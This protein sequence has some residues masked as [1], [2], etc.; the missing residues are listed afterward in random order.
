MNFIYSQ[1]LFFIPLI[2]APLILYLI[3]RKKPK[4]MVFS[5]LF[6]LKELAQ[7]INQRT[8]LKDILLLIIRTLIVFSIVMF[9]ASPYLGNYSDY[10]PNLDTSIYIYVDTSTSM[11]LSD[12]NFSVF[13]QTLSSI[14]KFL[15]DIPDRSEIVI[16][17]SDPSKKFIGGKKDAKLFLNEITLSGMQEDIENIVADADSFFMSDKNELNKEFLLFSDGELKTDNWEY[18]KDGYNYSKQLI[19]NSIDTK[20]RTDISIDSVKFDQKNQI[21]C[22]LSSKKIEK[23]SRTKL[24]LYEN[25]NKIY[26]DNIQFENTYKKTEIITYSNISISDKQM[27]FKVD[28]DINI[29]NNIF[30]FIIQGTKR[31]KTLIVGN[32]DDTV[33]KNLQLLINDTSD[34]LFE[35]SQI[36]FNNINTVNMSVY[37]VILFTDLK[38]ISSY[39]VSQLMNFFRSGR[40]VLIALGKDLNLNDYNSNLIPSL[41]FPRISGVKEFKDSYTGIKILTISHP[42]FDKVFVNDVDPKSLEINRYYELEPDGWDIL[43]KVNNSPY[44]LEK[45]IS[46]GK[47][48][49][50][51]SGFDSGS[52]NLIENGFLIPLIYNSIKYF[53]QSSINSELYYNC[54][55]RITVD[56]GNILF[57]PR[58]VE[59]S[60]QSSQEQ[61]IFL[62]YDGFYKLTNEIDSSVKY[63]A[64]NNIREDIDVVSRDML[65]DFDIIDND[66]FV[67]N[68]IFSVERNNYSFIFLYSL[69]VLLITEMLIAR[70]L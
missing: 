48:I 12:N 15:N 36:D 68:N 66:D 60:I 70:K 55:D 59:V 69:I 54:G 47:I 45:S 31:I 53:D 58:S 17:T 39:T 20:D 21:A 56:K 19:L 6:I 11:A 25:G 9:F 3:F 41:K 33:V 38:R 40:S 63:I 42:V 28:D 57:D 13:D 7:R 24:E 32:K 61:N 35:S 65:S 46:N 16:R 44:I 2:I 34:S 18:T 26:S 50:L 64:V 22:Y 27:F 10:D 30:N 62:N 29:M 5:S 14:K 8:R 43:A 49:L 1:Y 51:S 52:S 37:D 67:K 4:Q 23:G